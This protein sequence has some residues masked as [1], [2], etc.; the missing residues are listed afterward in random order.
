MTTKVGRLSIEWDAHKDLLNLKKHGIS[1][2]DA[3][4]VFLDENRVELYDIRHSETEDRYIVI[5][6]VKDILFVI[7]TER[8]KSIRIISAR[9]ATPKERELYY[10]KNS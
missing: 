5:G 10:G 6:V 1:F 7:Y 4:Y 9:K 3:A 8:G 2:R